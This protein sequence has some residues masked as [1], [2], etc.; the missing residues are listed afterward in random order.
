ML[1]QFKV[2]Q[3][4]DS[5]MGPAQPATNSINADES[6]SMCERNWPRKSVWHFLHNKTFQWG[7]SL[8]VTIL[9]ALIGWA[10]IQS[11]S[12]T[13]NIRGAEGVNIQDLKAGR[14]INISIT[15]ESR[16]NTLQNSIEIP[17]IYA[18]PVE[19]IIYRPSEPQ[20]LGQTKAWIKAKL[21]N[22]NGT[23]YANNVHVK[24]LTDDGTGH[25]TD[26]DSWNAQM[27]TPSLYT[28]DSIAPRQDRYAV[29]KPDIPSN[30]DQLYKSREATFKLGLY[31]TW[32]DNEKREHALL[33]LSELKHN[34]ELGVLLFEVKESLDSFHDE[35]LIE[36]RIAGF[37]I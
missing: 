4:N 13:Q 11:R 21:V 7:F 18:V 30:A 8:F 22:Q 28:F 33:N 32:S 1:R 3:S 27:G 2:R 26:S 12:Q 34:K 37:R 20:A 16:D 6:V 29:W 24:F 31:V 5:L 23:H 10:R 25:K 35:A 17:F 9:L 14:D 19:F 15:R 36:A